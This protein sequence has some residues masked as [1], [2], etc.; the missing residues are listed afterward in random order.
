MQEFDLALTVQVPASDWHYAQRRLTYLETML[1][2]VVRDLGE[3]QEW[4]DAGEL[5][6]LRLPGLPASRAGVTGRAKAARW[7]RR[8]IGR[9][10]VYHVTSLPAPAF[11]ALIARILDLPEP[12]P[13][14]G[15][16]R[17]LPA[18]A[19]LAPAAR[20]IEPENTAPA[21]VLP[22]MR[23]MRGPAKG[24]LSLAWRSLPDHLPKGT[25]LPSVTEAATVLVNLGLAEKIAR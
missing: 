21:W 11:D 20:E 25:I 12:D 2:H 14:E 8:R 3:V 4:F 5:A 9:H 1:L 23:L 22:L 24:S 15:A 18:L 6:A 16:L 7:S 10:L 17:N 13:I 19:G